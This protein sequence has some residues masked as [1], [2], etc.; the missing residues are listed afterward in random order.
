MN[1]VFFSETQIVQVSHITHDGWW[2]ENTNEHV[3]KGTALGKD[4]T[5]NLYTPSS[6]DKIARYDRETNT[7]S[8]EIQNRTWDEYFNQ[9]G[10]SF[11]IGEPDGD[12]PD[13]A[14]VEGPPEFDA[15][16]QTVLHKDEQWHIYDILIGQSF[17]DEY[18][19]E[20]K[21][22][23]YNFELPEKCTFIVPPEPLSEQHSPKLTNGQWQQFLD[24]RGEVA[25]A[26]DR[27]NG[28][29]YVID[30]LGELPAT[31]TLMAPDLYDSWVNG[32][33]QYDIERHRPLKAAEEKQWRDAKLHKILSRIDQYE[34]DQ[35]Y[36]TELRTS[37]IRTKEDYL[38]L[39]EVR[40]SL[41]DYP[42]R[43]DFPFGDRPD[44]S[45]LDYL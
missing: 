26:I 17:Y 14:I 16:T 12:F 21:V 35:S 25:Y 28:E 39:L 22:S 27:D 1:Q 42:D 8:N 10:Q 40:K 37:P 9:Y 24:H 43:S 20:F 18:G 31:H 33:W 5:L 38:K 6:K 23:D 36:P 4:F 2:I 45:M 3:V 15:Q 19:N 29:S 44:L 11:I 7:W 32:Q 30:E 34:K 13:W 41:S